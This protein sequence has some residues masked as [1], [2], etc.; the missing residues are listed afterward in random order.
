MATCE[1][2]AVHP[3]DSTVYC[4]VFGSESYV[5]LP[6]ERQRSGHEYMITEAIAL[7]NSAHVKIVNLAHS[8]G[9][10]T[11]T[12]GRNDAIN[13]TPTQTDLPNSG[14]NLPASA[15][16][17]ATTES[18]TV[19]HREQEDILAHDIPNVT[20]RFVT[21]S[22]SARPFADEPWNCSDDALTTRSEN[23]TDSQPATHALYVAFS[24]RS[25]IY[26]MLS[27]KIRSD[28]DAVHRALAIVV[29][30]QR[31]QD[32]TRILSLTISPSLSFIRKLVLQFCG[33]SSFSVF[34]F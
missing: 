3:F 15:L 16:S 1:S 29:T 2:T 13:G 12:D 23:A 20:A 8:G 7:G 33:P 25:L 28:V 32:T 17:P 24:P 5:H 30:Q 18:E 6:D 31:K 11:S 4:S 19:Q 22:P 27:M 34:S 10:F 9:Q 14:G 26:S 21:P